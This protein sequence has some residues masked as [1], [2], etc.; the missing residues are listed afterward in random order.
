MRTPGHIP[1]PGSVAAAASDPAAPIA[2]RE[3]GDRRDG[4]VYLTETQ[5]LQLIG[6]LAAAIEVHRV[7]R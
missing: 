3:I 2:Y 1:A 7:G 4:I 6:R 5:A